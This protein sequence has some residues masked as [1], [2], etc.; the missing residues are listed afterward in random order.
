MIEHILKVKIHFKHDFKRLE[1]RL[2]VL[3]RYVLNKYR[4]IKFKHFRAYT[5]IKIK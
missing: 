3:D 4:M 5:G 1:N 2:Y